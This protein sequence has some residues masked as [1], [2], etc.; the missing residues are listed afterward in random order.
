VPIDTSKS[1]PVAG[2]AVNLPGVPNS[3]VFAAN[4]TVAYLGTNAGL[5]SFTPSTN[6]ATLVDASITGKVLAVSPNGTVVIVS[7]AAKDPQGHVIQTVVPSQRLWVFSSANGNSTQMFVKPAA[8]AA[9]FDTDGF[10]DYIVTNDGTGNIYVFSPSL[11]LQTI[12]IGGTSSSVA[13]LA[14]DEF[15][16]VANS[17]GLEVVA[18][19]NNVQQPTATNPPTNSSTIQLVQPVANAD[20]IVAVDS[21]GVDVETATVTS[22]FH[23]NPPLPFVLSPANC[24]PNISYSNQFLDFGIGPFTASQLLVATNGSRVVVLPVG[25]SNVLSAVPGSTPSVAA[26]PLAG[27]GTQAISGGM[28]PDGNT[29]WVGVAGTNTVDKIDLVG[30]T[31]AAQVA[32]SFKKSDSSAAPPDIV[33]VQPK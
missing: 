17:A 19:C 25:N 12:N 22:I 6:T 4:G 13:S 31:D 15:V 9:T 32:T 18:T 20:T 2:T 29:V 5:V 21:S 10:R 30:G 26:I 8:V 14:S 33:A 16:Y 24:Q 3:L 1:P 7:N 11:S 27:G 23:S 28:T